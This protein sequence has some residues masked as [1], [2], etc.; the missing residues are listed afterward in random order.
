[1]GLLNA[2][3]RFRGRT[4]APLELAYQAIEL[5]RTVLNECVGCQDQT[6]AAVGGLQLVEFRATDDIRPHA[7]DLGPARMQLFEQ[8]LMMFYT[9]IRRRASTVAARQVQSIP[10]NLGTLKTMRQMVD[11][12]YQCLTGTR[13]LDPFGALL[14]ESW[15]LKRSLDTGVANDQI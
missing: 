1:V 2:L 3:H 11:Q 14:H 8:H 15:L 10:N 7:V 12:A 6:L 4:V 9:G 13:D 5:E